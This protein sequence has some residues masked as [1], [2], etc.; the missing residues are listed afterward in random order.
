MTSNWRA[1]LA[2]AVQ[3]GLD[4][5][6]H[7]AVAAALHGQAAALAAHP[8]APVE[9]FAPE[10]PVLGVDA[11][12]AGWVGVLLGPTGRATVHVGSTIRA[13]VDQVQENAEIA[14]VA[15]DIPIGLP[16]TGGR[17]ADALA[18]RA[19]P[20][21]TS[22][23]FSTLTR[24]AYESESYA[25]GREQN[26]A[27]T[28]GELS[29]SAQAYALRTKILDVDAW[30]RS[31]PGVTVIEVHPEL[32]FARLAGAPV[33]ASKKDDDGVRARRGAL[34]G[35]GITAP[36]W[37]S[38]SGFAEDDL[39]DACAAAWS[40]ARHLIGEGESFPPA[41]EVFS[42]GLPAAIRV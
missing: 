34:A 27:A 16:D 41:P 9:P 3:H 33:L 10:A 25:E 13:L 37:F 8:D 24:S 23:V 15:I 2:R 18:R 39:L 7:D 14:V 29:A 5:E 32:S 31:G 12:R 36:G 19:L 26:L 40:A 4:S 22:S 42:D 6:G 17:Q 20:G 21:K 30:V 28:Q 1:D 38:G 11:C 35:V